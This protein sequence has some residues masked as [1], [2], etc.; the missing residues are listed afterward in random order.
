MD[1][2]MD[3]ESH[4]QRMRALSYADLDAVLGA[5][6][7]LIL[8]PHADDESLGCGM[9]AE[10]RASGRAAL[11]GDP[12]GFPRLASGLDEP[13]AGPSAGRAGARGHVHR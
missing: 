12:H 8:P 11:G 3:A 13:P 9:I 2:V 10:A 6:P 7:P 1:T 4:L 5:H